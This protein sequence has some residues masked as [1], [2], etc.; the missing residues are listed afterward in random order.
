MA[1]LWTCSWC[2]PLSEELCG[3]PWMG[4]SSSQ[5]CSRVPVLL[6]WCVYAVIELVPISSGLSWTPAVHL[7]H[8]CVACR[9]YRTRELWVW[10]E[11]ALDLGNKPQIE[12]SPWCHTRP[13]WQGCA[14]SRQL[15][16]LAVN[17][18]VSWL[19]WLEVQ[20]MEIKP[21]AT[22]TAGVHCCFLLLPEPSTWDMSCY[23]P[24]CSLT[25]CRWLHGI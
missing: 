16:K 3:Q 13:W 25:M 21:R 11:E 10:L 23:Q 2:P 22:V 24:W 7:H 18:D 20:G 8:D 5:P 17:S 15:Q 6:C 4:F 1:L 19:V 14:A 12:N 9:Q